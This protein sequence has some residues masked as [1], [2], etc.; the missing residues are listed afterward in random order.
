MQPDLE[1]PEFGWLGIVRMVKPWDEWMF[2]LFPNRDWDTKGQPTSEKYL[3]RIHQFIGDD[4]PAEILNTSKWFIN[5]I[6]AE[7]YSRGNM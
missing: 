5:E 6:V 2:I 1:H 3:E 7:E 4:T